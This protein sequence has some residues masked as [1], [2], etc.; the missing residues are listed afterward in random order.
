MGPEENPTFS[1]AN[2]YIA[3]AGETGGSTS[4]CIPSSLRGARHLAHCDAGRS[5]GCLQVAG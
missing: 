3:D 2:I 5:E 4:E 1:P